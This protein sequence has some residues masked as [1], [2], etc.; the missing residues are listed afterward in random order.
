MSGDRI[1]GRKDVTGRGHG[2]ELDRF[3]FNFEF[4]FLSFTKSSLSSKTAKLFRLHGESLASTHK[5]RYLGLHVRRQWFFS[6]INQEGDQT[7]ASSLY[8]F[9]KKNTSPK[10]FY[11][12]TREFS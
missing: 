4:A 3:L 9:P 1:A 6:K 5:L 2:C 7:V 10:F 11:T 8:S 12:W